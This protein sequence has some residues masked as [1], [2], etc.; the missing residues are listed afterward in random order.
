ML[1]EVLDCC[2]GSSL[3]F[4]QKKV[5]FCQIELHSLLPQKTLQLALPTFNGF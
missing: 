1:F 2:W 4:H 5:G 3:G